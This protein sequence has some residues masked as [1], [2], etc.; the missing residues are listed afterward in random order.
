[1]SLCPEAKARAAMT[2]AEFWDHVFPQP[3]LVGER[4]PDAQE[5]AE[6]ELTDRLADSCPEC[7]QIGPCAYDNEGRAL[8]HVTDDDAGDDQ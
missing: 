1:M 4:F 8:I 2:D 3:D 7:G 6:Y 5:I